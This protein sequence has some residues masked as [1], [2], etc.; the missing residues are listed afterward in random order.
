MERRRWGAGGRWCWDRLGEAW[1]GQEQGCW[2]AAGL[3][4]L[5]WWARDQGHVRGGME[6][7]VLV[8]NGVDRR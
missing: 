2:P 6:M 3:P 1:K 5:V 8:E 7:W 4:G